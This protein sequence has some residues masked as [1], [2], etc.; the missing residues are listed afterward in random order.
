MRGVSFL[1]WPTYSRG[2]VF[3]FMIRVCVIGFAFACPTLALLTWDGWF[4]TFRYGLYRGRKVLVTLKESPEWWDELAK[5]R[6][7]P[8]KAERE[9]GFRQLFYGDPYRLTQPHPFK[10]DIEI[11]RQHD[12]PAEQRHAGEPERGYP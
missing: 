3:P 7:D 10:E 1:Q 8:A 12:H 2:V 11:M 6:Q 5:L 4:Q 9:K